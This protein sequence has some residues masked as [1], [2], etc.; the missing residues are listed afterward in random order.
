M[1]YLGVCYYLFQDGFGPRHWLGDQQSISV[2][3]ILSNVIFLHA[4]N[5]YWITSIVPG[6]WSIG[7][8]VI[9][10]AII[11]FLYE[12]IKNISQ[13]FV[14]FILTCFFR[15]FLFLI[16]LKF[17]LITSE[18]LWREYLFL[19]FPSHL[20]IFSLGILMYFIIIK[21]DSDHLSKK[22]LL[23]F[24]LLLLAQQAV[25]IQ[26]IFP[27]HILFGITFILLGISL[28]SYSPFILVNPII[29]YIG[30]ISFSMYLVHFAVLHWLSHFNL[31]TYSNN[32]VLNYVILYLIVSFFT[33]IISTLFYNLIEIPFQNLGRKL[34]LQ[35]E[36][37]SK[38]QL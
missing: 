14:F 22:W 27:N 2:W 23:V 13:A 12:K 7:V 33:I 38:K 36:T 8:E 35:S 20:P 16:L 4:F 37:S 1:Y 5:P 31:L 30:K 18:Q 34:I 25:G 17:P 6:G 24:S 3:N 9:F 26:F 32:K 10:Y 29:N 15:L 21:N 11:P 28:S 19:Y